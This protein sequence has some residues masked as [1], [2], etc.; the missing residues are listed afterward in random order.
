[1][2][3]P[4]SGSGTISGAG[5]S[6]VGS[7]NV[8]LSSP[9]GSNVV[10][11][12]FFGPGAAEVGAA[13]GSSRG[14]DNFTVGTLIGRRG[15]T[16]PVVETL[17][18]LI[19]TGSL[20]Y[21]QFS[22]RVDTSG[23]GIGLP[24]SVEFNGGIESRVTLDP[25][26]QTFDFENGYAHGPSELVT[27]ESDGRFSVYRRTNV[28][29]PITY[30]MYNQGSGNTELPLDFVSFALTDR[31]G[32]SV[33]PFGLRSSPLFI[34]VA[35]RATFDGV[36]YGDALSA[37]SAN[38]YGLRGLATLTA[39]F[40]ALTIGGSFTAAAT[41]QGTTTDLGRFTLANGRIGQYSPNTPNGRP[42]N[43]FSADI[44]GTPGT[45]GS[46]S[47]AF[48]GPAVQ[49]LGATVRL[50]TPGS[51]VTLLGQGVIVAKRGAVDSTPAPPSPPAPTPLANTSFDPLTR[52]D[53]FAATV[54]SASAVYP[55]NGTSPASPKTM[56][57]TVRYDAATQSYT[58]MEGGASTTFA[59]G[60]K[61]ASNRLADTFRTSGSSGN[62]TVQ[63][64]PTGA[65][66]A[67][68]TRYVA[69]GIWSRD[70]KAGGVLSVLMR[71]FVFGIPTTISDI[72][73]TGT[74]SFGVVL[75]GVQP[76]SETSP[77]PHLS[78]VNGSGLFSVDWARATVS[79]NGAVYLRSA[80]SPTMPAPGSFDYTGSIANGQLSGVLTIKDA[81][82]SGPS[83]PANGMFYGPGAGEIGLSYSLT[84]GTPIRSGVGVITGTRATTAP[85]FETLT[86]LLSDVSLGSIRT[87]LS[88]PMP[89]QTTSA[90]TPIELSGVDVGAGYDRFNIDGNFAPAEAVPA[91]SDARF[92]TFRRSNSSSVDT[93][94]VYRA[95]SGNTELALS[96]ASLAVRDFVPTAAGSARVTSTHAFGLPT[97]ASFLPRTT[98][99]TSLT[100]RR[101][102]ADAPF[103]LFVEPRREWLVRGV[104]GGTF[105]QATIAGFAPVVRLIAE[106]NSST[107]A[108]FEYRRLAAEIGITK[109]F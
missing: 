81:V 83:G 26:A 101:L 67:I 63:L 70:A 22:L 2:Y 73:T 58:V 62:D 38:R 56:P 105:R 41:F 12:R 48:F 95:G 65:R 72:P 84:S 13:F 46:V 11:G 76:I 14:S 66:G 68:G 42:D 9:I 16:A 74:A 28:S 75:N 24:V 33:I 61:V 37:G 6:L 47:G 10:S 21:E 18:S 60:D 1:M 31:F 102:S 104:V 94:R 59:P 89:S 108:L 71:S 30:R 25:A 97:L 23:Q 109:A 44:S 51:G 79:G 78:Q 87:S 98:L 93:V 64:T 7:V 29:T 34:P 49:E 90:G 80:F 15:T 35:G 39:D 77:P 69:G 19:S 36:F 17:S 82:G 27:A 92:T 88:I 3:D 50:V 57:L 91:E 5:R 55:G 86:S 100:A 4:F 106:R 85:A 54:Q 40:G 96:Y 52:S 53:T 43:L 20:R 45:I 107:V 32:L 103:F 99:F 8:S